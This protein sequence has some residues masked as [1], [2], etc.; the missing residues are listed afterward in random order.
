[1]II[2]AVLNNVVAITLILLITPTFVEAQTGVNDPRRILKRQI[3]QQQ[4]QQI[5]RQNEQPSKAVTIDGVP[6]PSPSQQKKEIPPFILNEL[7]FSQTQAFSEEE[8]IEF[9]KNIIGEATTLQTLRNFATSLERHYIDHGFIARVILPVQNIVEGKVDIKIIEARMGEKL[10]EGNIATKSSFVEKRLYDLNQGT[11]LDV[12]QLEESML[13]INNIYDINIRA[14]L[15]PGKAF[16]SSDVLLTILEPEQH[17]LNL[18]MDNYGNNSTGEFQQQIVYS[19]NS[20]TGYRDRFDA[21]LRNATGG[22]DGSLAYSFYWPDSDLRTMIFYAQSEVDIINGPVKDLGIEGESSIALI[23]IRKSIFFTNDS[24]LTA[25][26]SYNSSEST[27]YIE[28]VELENTSTDTIK[29]GLSYWYRSINAYWSGNIAVSDSSTSGEFSS[30]AISDVDY[31]LLTGDGFY[32]HNFDSNYSAMIR[33]A[34]QLSGD[35]QLPSAGQFQIGGISS[36][37]GYDNGLLSGDQGYS[38]GF[39]FHRRWDASL[40]Q[41]GSSIDSYVFIDDGE[42]ET[43]DSRRDQNLLSYGVGADWRLRQKIDIR[44]TLARSA[45]SVEQ[46]ASDTVFYIKVNIPLLDLW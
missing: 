44:T 32:Y 6:A 3:D 15:K 33:V 20:V 14:Q 36:V 27:T 23:D 30:T 17:Q 12:N 8:L 41:V 38:V 4:K 42:V 7:V 24:L 28:S 5:E 39:E 18:V 35:D 25:G 22:M 10:V 21:N 11:L 37:R 16:A 1:M 43:G 46:S 34:F 26:F 19:N 13:G 9:S 31:N 40:L 2:K 29:L 45:S